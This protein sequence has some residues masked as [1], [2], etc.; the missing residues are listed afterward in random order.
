MPLI[1]CTVPTSTYVQSTVYCD[2]DLYLFNLCSIDP[3][4]ILLP[5]SLTLSEEKR[6][7][8][9]TVTQLR[10]RPP[11]KQLQLETQLAKF[12]QQQAP[13]QAPASP[14]PSANQTFDYTGISGA[15]LAMSPSFL[16]GT[17]ATSM[18]SDLGFDPTRSGTLMGGPLQQ[19]VDSTLANRMFLDGIPASPAPQYFVPS[20]SSQHLPFTSS[21]AA[22]ASPM[23]QV[24]SRG[25]PLLFPGLYNSI[26]T[27]A[28]DAM[29]CGPLPL[30][31]GQN[32]SLDALGLQQL[33]NSSLLGHQ[34][35]MLPP[36]VTN[37][38]THDATVGATLSMS[39][40]HGRPHSVDEARAMAAD[41]GLKPN[42]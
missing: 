32:A 31:G 17:A 8:E 1:Y 3:S 22:F 6:S 9:A 13:A 33:C 27:I 38:Q 5:P 34:I 19:S 10:E 39:Q 40:P 20:V 25:D 37:W 35:N 29:G 21:S 2:T 14:L 7:L 16:T 41:A 4:C 28:S 26:G 23:S 42:E 30:I 24:A 36:S 11:E 15:S 12:S 18:Q